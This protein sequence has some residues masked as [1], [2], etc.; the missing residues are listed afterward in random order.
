MTEPQAL[1]TRSFPA[2]LTRVAFLALL[3]LVSTTATACAAIGGIF[4]A[5]L[6]IGLIVAAVVVVLV[7][8][9]VRSISSR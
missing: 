7:L 1:S 2:P 4:K 9:L 3:L 6:W 5:G 8:F